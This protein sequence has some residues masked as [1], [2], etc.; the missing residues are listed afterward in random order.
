M[1]RL[2]KPTSPA[3]SVWFSGQPDFRLWKLSLTSAP[4]RLRAPART[5]SAVPS[6]KM[7]HRTCP[8]NIWWDTHSPRCWRKWRHA[9]LFP[10]ENSQSYV[11]HFS[12]ETADV[13][14]HVPSLSRG[15]LF[16]FALFDCFLAL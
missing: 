10:K 7:K 8:R 13:L 14:S 6:M 16:P 9:P 5:S 2:Q 11:R 15:S 3:H 4:R 12:L 1:L